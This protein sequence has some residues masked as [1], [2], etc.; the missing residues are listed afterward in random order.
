M[1]HRSILDILKTASEISMGKEIL[2]LSERKWGAECVRE[3]VIGGQNIGSGGNPE[4]IGNYS[5]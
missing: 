3:K 4:T 1:K 2:T 5:S